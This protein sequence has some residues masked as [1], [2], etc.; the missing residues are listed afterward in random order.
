MAASILFLDI[1]GVLFSGP[2]WLLPVNRRLQATGAKST[3][4]EAS[5]LV[6]QG[7][8]STPALSPSSA[9]YATP[10]APASWSPVRGGT[11]WSRADP[12]KLLE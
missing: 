3:R 12:A 7:L 6:G 4:R 11:S 2:A 8:F 10:P 1:D 9:R 5:D